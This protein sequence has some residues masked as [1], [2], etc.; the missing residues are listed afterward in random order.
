MFRNC[1]DIYT[2][3]WQRWSLIYCR[4]LYGRRYF[5]IV[6]CFLKYNFVSLLWNCKKYVLIKHVLLTKTVKIN[7]KF[8]LENKS[9]FTWDK[10]IFFNYISLK[11]LV[12]LSFVLTPLFY[13]HA[14]WRCLQFLLVFPTMTRAFPWS[15]VYLICHI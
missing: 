3:L 6:L 9:I 12:V 8:V 11:S 2:S 13:G 14:L 1:L 5:W 10:T 15:Y 7:R 4:S